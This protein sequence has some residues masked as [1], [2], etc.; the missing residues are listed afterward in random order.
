MAAFKSMLPSSDTRPRSQFF[1]PGSRISIIRDAW[2]LPTWLAVGALVQAGLCLVLPAHIAVLPV[3]L[4]LSTSLI[5]LLLVTQGVRTNHRMDHVVVGKTSA[6]V[7]GSTTPARDPLLVIKLAARSNHPLGTLHPHIIKIGGFFQQMIR[8]LDDHSDDYNY[9]GAQTYLGAERA[10]ANEIMVLVYFRDYA[11]LHKFAHTAEV[12]RA[13]WRY[14]NKEVMKDASH[15][16]Q[17]AIMHETYQVP[18]RSWE[19]VYIN[20]HPTGLGATTYKV[21][22]GDGTAQWANPLVDASRGVL[23]TSKGRMAASHGDED[24]GYKTFE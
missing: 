12:H 19:S 15:G 14:W 20:Y 9:L 10:T 2:T 11:G 23:S 6:Q 4:Y 3:L 5:D 13:A 8:H 7:P 18:A 22:T 24:L 1:S 21:N 17:F 16:Q